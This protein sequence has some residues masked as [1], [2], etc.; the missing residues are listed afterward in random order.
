MRI[1]VNK[2]DC[3]DGNGTTRSSARIATGI[4]IPSLLTRVPW[5][6]AKIECV[7]FEVVLEGW[8]CAEEHGPRR[9]LT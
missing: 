7:C 5:R 9:V 3:D 6:A 4:S 8:T 2:M 1:D